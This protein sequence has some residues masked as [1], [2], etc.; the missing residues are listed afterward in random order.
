MR[1]DIKGWN[2]CPKRWTFRYR[3]MLTLDKKTLKYKFKDDNLGAF[4]RFNAK[5]TLFIGDSIKQKG[6]S[7]YIK[8]MRHGFVGMGVPYNRTA[9]PANSSCG[10]FDK[11]TIGL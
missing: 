11:W 8:P 2:S 6:D 1:F 4:F 5:D 3:E 9:W 10:A 7:T